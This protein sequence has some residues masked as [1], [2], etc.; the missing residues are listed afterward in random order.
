MCALKPPEA[1]VGRAQ[2]VS[3]HYHNAVHT[4]LIIFY[5]VLNASFVVS[6]PKRGFS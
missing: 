6:R 4:V 5:I 2:T 3:P 1:E